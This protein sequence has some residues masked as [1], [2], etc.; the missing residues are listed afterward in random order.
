MDGGIYKEF[1]QMQVHNLPPHSTGKNAKPTLFSSSRKS[2]DELTGQ[3][4]TKNI[5]YNCTVTYVS[6]ESLR[7]IYSIFISHF[8][9]TINQRPDKKKASRPCH[10]NLQQVQN[11]KY[12][13]HV[14]YFV[15]VMYGILLQTLEQRCYNMRHQA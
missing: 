7:S 14:S 2:G 5:D 10:L 8:P 1:H 6:C 13:I 4:E 3:N 15:H 9:V 12:R 11:I